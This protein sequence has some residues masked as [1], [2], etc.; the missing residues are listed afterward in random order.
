WAHP[1]NQV[2]LDAVHR[3]TDPDY[4]DLTLKMRTG[5]EAGAVFDQLY[6]RGEIVIHPS[7]VERHTAIAERAASSPG[8]LV[9]ADT[10][11]QVAQ[12]NA[13][14]RDHR[15][16]PSEAQAPPTT[17]LTTTLTTG[18]GVE[19]TAGDR[20]ATRRND[21]DLDIANRDQWTI[22]AINH[23]G[24]LTLHGRR[25]ARTVPS[26][27]ARAHV[28]LAYATTVHGA[29]GET[30]DTAHVL[31]GD[32]T[33]A[34]AAYVAMTRGRHRNTAH[35]VA[36]TVADARTQWVET[37]NRDRADLGPAR[38]RDTAAEAIELHG[39][40]ASPRPPS[41][42]GSPSRPALRPA[43]RPPPLLDPRTR[44]PEEHPIPSS[45]PAP[46]PGMGR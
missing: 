34:A 11:E 2:T 29:Q 3:F 15:M 1:D 21:R 19:V 35:L 10:R 38:A 28:E 13:T 14:I 27:Y 36:D 9:V 24:D 12:L 37:F 30:V 44:R 8:D 25:G 18:T 39:S 42:P 40:T 43:L 26:D 32:T 46:G 22:T 20:V 31:L 16:T 23:D 41:M 33:G 4:A 5:A 7:D 17:A 45:S 6:E